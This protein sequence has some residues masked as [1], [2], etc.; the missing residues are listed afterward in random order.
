MW[1]FCCG[2][3]RSASTLQ[4]QIASRLIQDFHTGHA[5]GW[6]DVKRFGQ[7]QATYG[8]CAG[9]KLVK[10]HRCTEAIAAEFHQ[11]NARGIYTFRDLRDVFA[12]YMKQR[13]MSFEALWQ[14]DLVVDCLNNY[15][16]WTTLPHVLVSQYDC[17]V[18]DIALEVQRIASHLA[19]SVCPEQATA[20]AQDYNLEQ[21]KRRI[22]Q[23]RD[24]LLQ[25]SHHPNNDRAL[26]DAHDEH[27]LLHIN[28]LDSGKIGRWKDDLTEE[29]VSRIE[30]SVAQWCAHHPYPPTLFL[31]N[32][33]AYSRPLARGRSPN[34]LTLPE[35]LP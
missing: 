29:Q 34:P 31:A 8:H 11:N 25:H 9:M 28:H 7:V 6:V 30:T 23:F 16:W 20:I 26:E 19:I 4:F 17:I 22:Q 3:Y 32:E 18:N 35:P 2:M 24:Q 13:R 1:I 27:S 14:E 15:H 21:Q 12:S 5:V 33:A 10:V